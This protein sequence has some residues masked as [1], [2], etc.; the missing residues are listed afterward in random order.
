M[1]VLLSIKPE[2]VEKIFSGEKLY[3]YRK[4]LFR[5]DDVSKVVVYATRPVAKLVGEFEIADILSDSIQN[6]WD[7]TKKFSGISR[8]FYYEYFS[9]RKNGYAIKI[10]EVHKYHHAIDPCV[11]EPEFTAPQSFRYIENEPW[12]ET[13]PQ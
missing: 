8:A 3:E 5:R 2:F 11:A 13:T 10:G 6:L 1:K 4:V 9:G 7:E 12:L